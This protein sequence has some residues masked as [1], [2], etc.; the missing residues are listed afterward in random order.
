MSSST[1]SDNKKATNKK[2]QSG[3]VNK[4]PAPSAEKHLKKE[5]KSQHYRGIIFL[6]K[7]RKTSE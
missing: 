7:E 2:P 1:E 4:S 6:Q 5:D 3:Q